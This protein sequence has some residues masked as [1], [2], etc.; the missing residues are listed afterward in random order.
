MAT[1]SGK[2]S[3]N[4]AY[5]MYLDVSESSYD[6]VANTSVVAWTL[7]VHSD[8]ALQYGSWEYTTANV[9]YSVYINGTRV[10][11]GNRTY[12]FR[13]Y[14]DL[15]VANGTTTV[16]HN[17]DGTKVVACSASY[18]TSSSP[19]GKASVSGNFTLTTIPRASE[20]VCTSPVA[21]AST[22]AVTVTQKSTSFSHI[23][24]YSTD[25]G[26]AYSEIGRDTA[27]RTY[28][29]A[30][31]D[32]TSTIPNADSATYILKCETYTN[33][34][35]EGTPL[36]STQN[37]VATVPSSYVPTIAITSI[38]EGNPSVPAT[39]PYI[40]GFSKLA[41]RTTFTGSANSTCAGRAV[42]VGNEI[43]TN[44]SSASVV[45]MQFTNAL[46]GTSVNVL[47]TTTDS[48]G[49]QGTATQ[50]E[51][52]YAYQNPTIH[53]DLTRA[54]SNGNTDPVGEYLQVRA[55]WSYDSVNSLN[56]ATI[57]IYLNEGLEYTY[58]PSVAVQ[59]EWESICLLE[60][61]YASMQFEFV[62]TIEDLLLTASVSQTVSKA[63]I[64]LSPYDDENDVG[65]T[66]GRMATGAGF[67]SAL[68]NY[69]VSGTETHLMDTDGKQVIET[70]DT[71]DLFKSGDYSQASNKPQINGVVLEGNKTS[72]G[73]KIGELAWTNPDGDTTGFSTKTV[74]LTGF[75]ASE[76]SYYE[77]LFNGL[78]TDIVYCSTG[79]IPVG[80]PSS[81]FYLA[82][83]SSNYRI[84]ARDVTASTDAGGNIQLTFAQGYQWTGGSTTGSSN[85][86]CIPVHILLY[87]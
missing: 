58:T 76:Y 59:D 17:E 37:I 55:K 28:S 81:L 65:V 26:T 70:I 69:F 22:Q 84:R 5:T 33:S 47:A 3:I 48:R 13:N 73:L 87:K 27:T 83:S 10:A 79:K 9:P 34:T 49:R 46:T 25:G 19:I 2:F 20:I 80:Q 78:Y 32:I 64:P 38:T 44:T 1:Y 66:I 86:I 54:D 14:K 60:D 12:D 50:A 45:D 53:V 62:A 29:W 42:Q 39:F 52:A 16:E 61:I 75:S 51:T 74:T 11:N 23:L 30:L 68:D 36:E 4:S 56:S 24:Y 57:K 41:V 71:D 72:A 67:R 18:C 31:P 82:V 43:I 77:V 63:I 85:N 8:K 15:T 7:R 40:V 21:M 6:I 35:Y